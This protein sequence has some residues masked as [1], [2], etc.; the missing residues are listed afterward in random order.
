MPSVAL[1]IARV[2]DTVPLPSVRSLPSRLPPGG[3]NLQASLRS[4]TA[5]VGVPLADPS[6]IFPSL[7]HDPW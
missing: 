7:K 4:T 6:Q 2:I 5:E 3:S 1:R